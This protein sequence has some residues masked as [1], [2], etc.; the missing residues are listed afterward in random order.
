MRREREKGIDEWGKA[1]NE[2]E[3]CETEETVKETT[4][5]REETNNE[6]EYCLI[7][8]GIWWERESLKEKTVKREKER[9]NGWLGSG[10][11]TENLKI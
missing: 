6:N 2:R 10:S 8:R 3:N 5:E 1:V 9:E 7:R 11:G 4:R